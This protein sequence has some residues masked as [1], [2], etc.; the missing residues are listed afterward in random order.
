MNS[1]GPWLERACVDIE[2]RSKCVRQKEPLFLLVM[3]VMLNQHL[4]RWR[5]FFFFWMTAAVKWKWNVSAAVEHSTLQ[6][7]CLACFDIPESSSS[8]EFLSSVGYFTPDLSLFVLGVELDCI[9]LPMNRA[10]SD[11]VLFRA[12]FVLGVSASALLS[13]SRKSWNY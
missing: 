12:A 5:E 13:L 4:S 1:V 7:L 2:W 9:F 10:L 11:F 6:S 8:L 3:Q